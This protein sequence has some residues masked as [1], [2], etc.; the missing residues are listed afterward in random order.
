MRGIEKPFLNPATAKVWSKTYSEKKSGPNVRN[1]RKEEQF[2]SMVREERISQAPDTGLIE[3][4][5]ELIDVST[6]EVV[7]R[8]KAMTCLQAH[9]LNGNLRHGPIQSPFRWRRCANSHQ[10]SNE[11][12]MRERP[13]HL[14]QSGYVN[15]VK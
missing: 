5:F 3:L 4:Y 6:N 7:G 12:S 10:S 1:R 13:S 9:I 8:K 15:P 2:S 14:R 11:P